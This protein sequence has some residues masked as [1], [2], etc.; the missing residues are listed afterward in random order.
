MIRL[1]QIFD[2]EK[3][4]KL[5]ISYNS[6]F[7]N[8]YNLKSYLNNNNYIILVE[9]NIKGF[10][11]IYNNLDYYELEMIIVDKQYRKNHIAT[12]LLN[13]FFDNYE[14]KDVLL[15]V[16]TNNIIAINLYKKYDFEI[17]NIR[18]KYYGNI[19]AYIMRKVVK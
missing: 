3:I 4:N 12:G 17:I 1:A 8:T 19:D 16:A 15:E 6:D 14:K 13:Y 10:L 11:I 18:K 7:L 2:I 5:G 9:E